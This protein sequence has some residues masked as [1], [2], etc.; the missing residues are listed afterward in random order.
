M[1]RSVC[2]HLPRPAPRRRRARAPGIEGTRSRQLA[3]DPASRGG[4]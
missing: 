3:T 2:V 1:K 4:V